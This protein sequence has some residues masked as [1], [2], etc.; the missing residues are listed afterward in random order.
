MSVVVGLRRTA[1]SSNACRLVAVVVPPA[2]I[3]AMVL[4]VRE[5]YS[6]CSHRDASHSASC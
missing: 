5:A 3:A 6:S 2:A 4:V 1:S